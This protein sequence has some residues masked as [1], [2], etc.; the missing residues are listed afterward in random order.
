MPP[1]AP[2]TIQTVTRARAYARL[3]SP[4]AAR[5]TMKYSGAGMPVPFRSWTLTRGKP[6]ASAPVTISVVVP[7]APSVTIDSPTNDASF[8]SND[9]VTICASGQDVTGTFVITEFFADTNSLGVV[10]NAPAGTDTCFTWTGVQSGTYSELMAQPGVF[11]EL[12][13]RQLT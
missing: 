3:S 8:E 12:A 7:P 4:N 11:A 9:D 2:L 1:S 6:P 5:P 10:T 13:K